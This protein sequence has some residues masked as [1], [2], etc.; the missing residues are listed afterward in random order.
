MN[1]PPESFEL[2]PGATITALVPLPSDPSVRSVRVD[3]RA[4][5]RLGETVIETLGLR[6]GDAWTPERAA[7]VHRAVA[8]QRAERAALAML[9]RR[10]LTAREVVERLRRRDIDAEIAEAVAADL[11]EQ[12]WLDDEA[13]AR[14]EVE[15]ARE[16]RPAGRA[17]LARRLAARG[18]DPAVAERVLDELLHGMDP[19]DEAL[20]VAERSLRSVSGTD[21]G[22]H[23]RR[24]AA[25]LSRRG[26]EAD[27]IPARARASG[28]HPRSRRPCRLTTR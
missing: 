8:T 14:T 3:G 6:P 13:V 22:R 5:A 7:A 9:G 18:I 26:F 2:A 19:W 23:A 10:A 1:G 15:H 11:T 25:T 16:R 28:P 20:R 4:V 24:V 21:S 17:G 12:G 27:L